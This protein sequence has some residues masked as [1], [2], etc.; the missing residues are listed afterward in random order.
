MTCPAAN[1]IP[2]GD[3]PGFDVVVHSRVSMERN[4]S[5]SP[6][7]HALGKV[8][9]AA[10]GLRLVSSVKAAGLDVSR[11]GALE[12]RFR[13]NLA[14]RE[15]YSRPYL[16][17]DDN[18][19][20]LSPGTGLWI[21]VNDENH[22]SIRTS[23]PGLDLQAAWNDAVDMEAVLS[24]ALD[25]GTWAFD[26]DFGYLMSEAAFCGSGL[27]ASVTLHAP[28]LVISGLAEAA[29]KRA[30]EAG[31]IVAGAYSGIAASAGALFDIALPRTWRDPERLALGRLEA[32]AKTLAEYER[33]ARDMLLTGSSWEILDVIGRAAGNAAGA[34]LVSRDEAAEIASGLRLGIA[35]GVLEGIR[36][37]SATELWVSM[38][39]PLA[40]KEKR[41][42]PD[43][44]RR[45]RAMRLAVDGLHFTERYG[46]V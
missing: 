31:F 36:L 45:A 27:L 32:A 9:L 42:E 29:F 35:C 30:M 24:E 16:L 41:G 34:R 28:A 15:L 21:A 17:N 3:Y 33:R 7:P 39:A 19:A 43:A 20:A 14:Q 44:A 12:P 13:V 11:I 6:F 10:L 37:E 38:G 1:P 26:A 5:D 25:G 4:V 8:E 40:N 23:R 46:N 2:S 22:L 18:V